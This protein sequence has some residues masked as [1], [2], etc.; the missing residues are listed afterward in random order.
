MRITKTIAEWVAKQ[1]T[2]PKRLEQ[3]AIRNKRSELV[4]AYY[5]NQ[6]PDDILK[7]YNTYPNYFK[8]TTSTRIDAPGLSGNYNSY[9]LGTALPEKHGSCLVISAKDAEPIIEFD[10][11]DV[12]MGKE[13]ETLQANIES[14]LL[15]LRT[16]NKVQKEFPEAFKLLPPSSVNTGLAINIKDIRCKLDP[17][18]CI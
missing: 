13:I 17:V 1:L 10:N 6:L 9:S 8:K 12:S 2:Q 15:S 5:L 4:R 14:A 16:Y 18:N 7:L 11:I 3:W